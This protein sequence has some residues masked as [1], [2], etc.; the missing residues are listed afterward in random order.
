M[1]HCTVVCGIVLH[2]ISLNWREGG[3]LDQSELDNTRREGAPTWGTHL[4]G[5]M[6]QVWPLDS[7]VLQRFGRPSRFTQADDENYINM[8]KYGITRIDKKACNNSNIWFTTTEYKWE[9]KKNKK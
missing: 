9:F 7:P 8:Q 6:P 3:T 1:N 2:C 5:M 4:G